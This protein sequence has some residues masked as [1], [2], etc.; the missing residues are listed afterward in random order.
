MP[1]DLL[2]PLEQLLEPPDAMRYEMDDEKMEELIDSIRRDG[3][4]SPLFVI[5]LPA[6][7][8]QGDVARDGGATPPNGLAPHNY[9]VRA[10]H[11]R[12]LAC[13]HIDYSPVPCRVFAEDEPAYAGLMATENLI[14]EDVT[15]FEEGCMFA[16]IA[17]TPGITEQEL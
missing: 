6:T 2:I 5:E 8:P 13:R 14:R 4:L 3:V 12:L 10:G 9:E 7:L 11:R 15:P 16:K 1:T 17:E